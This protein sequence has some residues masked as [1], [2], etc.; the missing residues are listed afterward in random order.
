[1]KKRLFFLVVCFVSFLG[2]GQNNIFDI[3]RSGSVAEMKSYL[4]QNPKDINSKNQAGFTGL[5]LACYRGNDAVAFFLLQNGADIN[6][7]T[8][9]GS[10]LTGAVVK[11]N[12]R[13]VELLIANNA[14]LDL[15]EASGLTA[16]HFAVQF[17]NFTMIT[18]LLKS[19]A[20]P[21]I[22]DNNGLSVLDYANS[23]TDNELKQILN[24]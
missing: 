17:R 14:N 21:N 18:L 7:V 9:S 5:T 24:F 11:G 19:T 20:N 13:V 4:E 10:A 2:F 1:M 15:Q 3:A 12:I 23:S 8:D 22:K 16:L 6:Y